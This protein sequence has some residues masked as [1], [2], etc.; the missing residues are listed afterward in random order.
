[1]FLVGHVDIFLLG[2][3]N[4]ILMLTHSHWLIGADCAHFSQNLSSVAFCWQLRVRHSRSLYSIEIGNSIPQSE[5][6]ILHIYQ[7]NIGYLFRNGFPQVTYFIGYAYPSPLVYDDKLSSKKLPICV[8]I[9]DIYKN[10]Y[11]SISL[12][13]FNFTHSNECVVAFHCVFN[14]HLPGN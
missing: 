3:Y 4:C 14:L 12:Q 9:S 6:Q 7:H 11:F 8:S 1:M 5:S 2:I 13:P 10:A